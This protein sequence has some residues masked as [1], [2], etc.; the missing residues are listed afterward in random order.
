MTQKNRYTDKAI[1]LLTPNTKRYQ[2]TV[3]NGLSLRVLPSGIKSWVV[4]IPHKGSI[5]DISIGHWPDINRR[6]AAQKARQLRRQYDLVPPR[7]YTFNDAYALWKS[8]KKGEI[9]SYRSERLRLEKY[10]LPKLRLKQIDQ[11]TA[12][13][14]INLLKLIELTGKRATMKR[15][16]MRTKEIFDLA[17]C[18]GYVHHNPINGLSRLFKPPKKKPRPSIP[19]QSLPE[20]L[21][22]MEEKA[23]K[24]IKHIFLLSLYSMLRPGEVAKLRWD[25]IENNTLTI[26]AE[27]MKMRR[28]H[29]VPLTAFATDLLREIK[30]D[31]KHK[32]SVFI[33]PGQKS[34]NHVNSQTLTNY[35]RSQDFFK[36]R[37]VPHGLRSIARSWLADQGISYE[38]AESCLAHVVGDS[39]SRAYQRSDF[40]EARKEVMEQWS[41][42]IRACA[43]SSQEN[44]ENPDLSANPTD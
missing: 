8:L 4:R 22:V 9:V 34:Y 11:I 43:Q 28:V 24:R 21:S 13:M 23:P 42:F 1:S 26:P 10:V 40:L 44:D 29:R 39:V 33:F 31:T 38:I 35:M 6:E 5:S 30:S 37:L 25:W 14:I 20:V 7:G 15:C 32:R 27:E 3:D 16:L 19:W 18:A 12:P 36:D 17:V 41:S 2:I